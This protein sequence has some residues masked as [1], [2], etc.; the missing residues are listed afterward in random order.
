LKSKEKILVLQNFA[1][2]KS[3]PGI[4]SHFFRKDHL[5]LILLFIVLNEG[6]T[7]HL[8]SFKGYLIFVGDQMEAQLTNPKL[9]K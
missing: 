2:S 4:S 5:I 7:I 8:W 1:L 9:L 6:A 3:Y